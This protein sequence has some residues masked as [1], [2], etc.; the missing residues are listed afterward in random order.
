MAPPIKNTTVGVVTGII[1]APERSPLI[2]ATGI[3]SLTVGYGIWW[4]YFDLLG[5]RVPDH[6]GAPLAVWLFAQ[7]PVTMAIAGGGAAMVSLIEHA[8]DARAPTGN[9]LLLSSS[10]AVVLLGVTVAVRALGE[11]EFP[12]GMAP[13]IAPTLVLAAMAAVVI[14]IVRPPPII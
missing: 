6:T 1:D 13:Q 9:S 2:V 14:G 5:R 12:P 4:N 8:G 11:D 10:V 7:L 3:V